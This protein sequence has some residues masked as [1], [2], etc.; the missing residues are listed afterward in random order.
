V[1]TLLVVHHTP[2]P[3]LH[4]LLE[5]VESGTRD[6]AIS[7]VETVLRPAL[8]ATAVD[9]L[10]ADGYVLGTPANIGYMSGALKHF[11][12]QVYYPCLGATA[13]R[14][15]VVYVHG[16]S[17]TTG[18]LNAIERITTGLGWRL[19]Q[20]PLEVVGPVGPDDLASAYEI[21]ATLAAYLAGEAP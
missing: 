4:A 2:S 11:F 15:Y 5:A 20:R 1:R 6:P 3:S 8:S 17:D 12:D 14:P 9:A 21:G 19:V 18:A 16:D 10:G 13:G 7:G